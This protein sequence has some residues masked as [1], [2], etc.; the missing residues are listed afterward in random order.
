MFSLV[1]ELLVSGSSQPAVMELGVKHRD[2]GSKPNR[3]LRE[4]PRDCFVRLLLINKK[5]SLFQ[6]LPVRFSVIWSPKCPTQEVGCY[7]YVFMGIFPKG[8]ID[9]EETIFTEVVENNPQT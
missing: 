8:Q 7:R 3:I 5:S 6:P 1:L 2:R 4:Q 9:T